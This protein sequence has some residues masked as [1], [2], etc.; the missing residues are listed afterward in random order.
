MKSGN[1]LLILLLLFVFS[2]VSG[3]KPLKKTTISGVV[4][5]TNLKPV[6]GAIIFIDNQKTSIVT[7]QKGFYKIRVSSKARLI[8][9][10]T[11]MNGVSE[12]EIGG[13]TMINFSLK[14]SA[15]SY[16]NVAENPSDEETVNLGYGTIKK[17]NM[18]TPV[19]RIDA[20]NSKYAAYRNIYDIIREIPG[21]QVNGNNIMIQG[22]S[23]INLSNQPLF[24][25]DGVIVNSV[26]EISPQ[27]VKSIEVLKGASTSIYGSRGANG[28]IL[29]YLIGS[30]NN[31]K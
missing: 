2:T 7:D 30:Q 17:N 9:A 4:L 27:T 16:K 31:K 19:D 24:V 29:I 13:R 12:A 26:N 14:A 5:D 11:I 22:P 8:S 6:P 15:S 1:L 10:F 21:V 20:T 23:S 25:V 18:T 3:Q 28:V